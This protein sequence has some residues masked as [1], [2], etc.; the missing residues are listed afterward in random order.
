VLAI[1]ANPQHDTYWCVIAG[2]HGLRD[3][4]AAV[5]RALGFQV[6]RSQRDGT[7]VGGAEQRA[8]EDALREGVVVQP[9]PLPQPLNSTTASSST[10]AGTTTATTG[11]TGASTATGAASSS[12]RGGGRGGWAGAAGATNSST[13]AADA[14]PS[15]P[16][17]SQAAA[18]VRPSELSLAQSWTE[19]ARGVQS[20]VTTTPGVSPVAKPRSWAASAAA[21]GAAATAAA[22]GAGDSA[23]VQRNARLAAA[24]GVRPVAG[25]GSAEEEA[26]LRMNAFA[27]SADL[28][29]WARASPAV[30]LRIGE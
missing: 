16:A 8:A 1:A 25:A 14:F 26:R 5:T 7:G 12:G 9:P 10:S 15:L 23:V 22:S 28:V 6:R 21:G 17:P 3:G 2:A 24:L 4:S 29:A 19:R 13:G 20:G 30:V 18:S 27:W 11:T